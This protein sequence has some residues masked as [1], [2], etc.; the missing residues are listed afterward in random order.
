MIFYIITDNTYFFAGIEHLLSCTPS[1]LRRISTADIR[2]LMYSTNA[3]VLLD[4]AHHNISIQEF[5]HL[6]NKKINIL[7]ILNVNN[8]SLSQLVGVDILNACDTVD[9]LKRKLIKISCGDLQDYGWHVYLTRT[10][11]V[12]LRLY[13]NGLSPLQISREILVKKK[14]VYS[15]IRKI[16]HKTGVKKITHL[17]LLRNILNYHLSHG[18]VE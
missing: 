9:V 6:S 3:T 8:D 1:K 13:L 14:T 4:G 5:Q 15:H 7:F 2:T 11:S 16:L 18:F 17:T 12:I 10:E